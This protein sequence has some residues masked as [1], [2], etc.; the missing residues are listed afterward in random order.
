[1]AYRFLKPVSPAA[2]ATSSS[3][4]WTRGEPVTGQRRMDN[5]SGLIFGI[6]SCSLA[7]ALAPVAEKM[8]SF[9]PTA[10]CGSGRFPKN[11]QVP[12]T[13]TFS[14]GRSFK[15]GMVG[16]LG[17]RLRFRG[18]GRGIA[19]GIRKCQQ[20]VWSWLL[21]GGG[22]GQAQ[23]FP[24][25][26]HRQRISV[27]LAEVVAVRFGVGCQRTQDG[28]GVRIHVRQGGHRRLAAGRP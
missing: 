27:L 22:H 11:P 13:C 10:R 21:R 2:V 4:S 9:Q 15:G 1:M 26:G 20:V 8:C 25:A 24:A 6:C 3:P 16:P 7:G 14:S 28:G 23:H 5:S 17:G 18:E 19:D 12:P